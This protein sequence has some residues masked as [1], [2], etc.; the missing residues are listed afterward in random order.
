M[1]RPISPGAAM[2]L[3]C[4]R[5]V[6]TEAGT[7][8]TAVP[9]ATVL[10]DAA[11]RASETGAL[12]PDPLWREGVRR[13][14]ADALAA[15]RQRDRDD[16]LDKRQQAALDRM[17]AERAESDARF[18]AETQRTE[19]KWRVALTAVGVFVVALFLWLARRLGPWRAAGVVWL[20]GML[21]CVP[22]AWMVFESGRNNPGWGALGVL[23]ASAALLSAPTVAA[24]FL[25]IW[26]TLIARFIG[27]A[28]F[29]REVATAILAATVLSF[30]QVLLKRVL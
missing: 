25:A 2:G 10:A 16:W 20:V 15:P 22:L 27:D 9:T 26:Y 23:I 13:G 3:I 1:R 29:R 11:T 28:H 19:L 7:A 6:S 24:L 21:V 18:R 8:A 4:A 17:A 14:L 12:Q 5:A 30:L